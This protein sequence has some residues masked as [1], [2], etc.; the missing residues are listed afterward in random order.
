MKLDYSVIGK[1]I[2]KYRSNINMSQEELSNRIGVSKPH[3]SHIETGST[4]LSLQV[5]VDVA[6]TLGV[7][8]DQLL[9][10]NI[11]SSIRVF[12]T[13]VQ[14]L[15]DDCDSYELDAMVETMRLVKNSIRNKPNDI[16]E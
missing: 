1:R 14:E 6:N 15:L 2:K 13:E 8:A 9:G 4:K 16:T 12:K 5:L 11:A 10:I 3:M 7:S